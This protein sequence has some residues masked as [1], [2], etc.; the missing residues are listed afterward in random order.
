VNATAAT[1]TPSA[2]KTTETLD[3]F[4]SLWRHLIPSESVSLTAGSTLGLLLRSGALRL[5]ALAEREAVS[6]PAMTGLVSRLQ[7]AG[8]V[9]RRADPSD[10]RAVLVELTVAGRALIED[11][12][13]R[14]AAEMEGL[15][16]LLDPGERASFNAAI[17]AMRR[18]IDHATYDDHHAAPDIKE[19]R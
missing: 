17:P 19:S 9:V 18:L 12:R 2:T 11:R 7:A 3:A 1:R 8:L 4:F 15:L 5:T 13:A 14:R 10:G 6:Q 16:D